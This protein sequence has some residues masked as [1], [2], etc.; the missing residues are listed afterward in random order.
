MDKIRIFRRA[1]CDLKIDLSCCWLLKVVRSFSCE[2]QE[3]LWHSH[4]DRTED[5][6]AE[7][8]EVRLAQTYV[9]TS[10]LCLKLAGIIDS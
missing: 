7:L 8:W 9:S 2:L 5:F 10:L 3:A 1:T 6:V 4:S